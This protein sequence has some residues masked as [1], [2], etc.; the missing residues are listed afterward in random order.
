M[1]ELIWY[2][3]HFSQFGIGLQMI[4]AGAAMSVCVC[5]FR[6]GVLLHRHLNHAA[7]VKMCDSVLDYP[8]EPTFKK[9]ENASF[10]IGVQFSALGAVLIGGYLNNREAVEAWLLSIKH[11]LN[12]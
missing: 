7:Q 9:L 2:F 4:Y 10:W 1:E 3:S 8:G 11:H 6:M 12:L 5:L